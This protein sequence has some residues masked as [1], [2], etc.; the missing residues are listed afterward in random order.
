MPNMAIDPESGRAWVKIITTR[1]EDG[2]TEHQCLAAIEAH[3]ESHHNRH[4]KRRT[5]DHVFGDIHRLLRMSQLGTSIPQP[6]LEVRKAM[7]IPAPDSGTYPVVPEK[8]TAE[9]IEAI[10]DAMNGEVAHG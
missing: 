9:D 2:F 5:V 7:S 4:W 10:L 3:R 6:L 1:L 8:P